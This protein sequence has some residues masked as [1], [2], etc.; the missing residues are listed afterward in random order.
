VYLM[1]GWGGW[2][3][4]LGAL[5]GPLVD[6]GYRVIAVDAPGHGDAEPGFMGPRRG[7]VTE[8]IEALEAAGREYGPASAVVGHS[9]G[10]MVAARTV[11][12]G[13]TAERLVLISPNPPFAE[14]LAHFATVLRLNPATTA[15]LR[16]ALEG[17]TDCS[18]D[19]FDLTTMGADGSMPDTL[20]LHD[21]DDAESPHAV[22]AAIAATWPNARLVSS[23][24]LGHYRILRAQRTVTA[25]VAHITGA[26]AG[27]T[28]PR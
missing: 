22:G 9:L 20:V 17:I 23:S 1:H 7:A 18:I 8:M 10:T 27:G 25:A 3:G 28:V 21:H 5:V 19:E 4:H 2:R 16:G 15:H 26:R 11:R 24:G 14:L 6:A 13:L 12:A